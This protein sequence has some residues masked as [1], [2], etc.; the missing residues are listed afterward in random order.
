M[1]FMPDGT[2]TYLN[3]PAIVYEIVQGTKTGRE[4]ASAWE[5]MRKTEYNDS[6][7]QL[8][9]VSAKSL[10]FVFRDHVH[11]LEEKRRTRKGPVR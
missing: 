10:E 2:G 8:L 5:A 4:L 3:M 1:E 11:P 9:E 7:R 6:E